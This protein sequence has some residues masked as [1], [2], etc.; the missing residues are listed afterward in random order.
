VASSVVSSE[1]RVCVDVAALVISLAAVA[2]AFGSLVLARRADRRA[3]RADQRDE[4]RMQREDAE[5]ADRRRGKPIVVPRGGA[6]TDQY[7]GHNYEVRNGGSAIITELALWIETGEGKVVS[8]RAGGPLPLAPNENA[9]M[10]VEVRP[11]RPDEQ[12][13]MVQW[14]DADGEHTEPTGIRPPPRH[15]G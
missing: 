4:L 13:L 11:P 6:S 2:I 5:A 14:R 10:T 15:G 1:G 9:H 8:T 12:K 7:V 3:H